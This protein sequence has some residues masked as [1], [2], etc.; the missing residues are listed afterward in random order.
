[1]ALGAYWKSISDRMDLK[2][3]AV[4]GQATPWVSVSIERGD[5]GLHA[6]IVY[7]DANLKLHRLHFGW[8]RQLHAVAYDAVACSIPPLDEADAMWMSK[9]CGRIASHPSVQG[10][11]YNLKYDQD[12]AFDTGTGEIMFGV[13][14]TGLGCATFVLAVFRSGGNPLV[15][16]V[17]WPDASADDKAIQQKF[18][19]MLLRSKDPD[20]VAQGKKIQGEVGTKRIRP[21]HVAGACLEDQLPVRHAQCHANAQ[22]VVAEIDKAA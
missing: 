22:R 18:V 16:V 1:M 5:C 12:V 20:K 10:I 15:D 11:P 7:R 14:S 21:D 4:D 17:G 19:D 3:Y 9:L 13:N 2:R 6:G 8:H